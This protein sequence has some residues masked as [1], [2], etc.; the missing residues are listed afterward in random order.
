[1]ASYGRQLYI[2]VRASDQAS[3]PLRRIARDV[4]SMGNN[5][6]VVNQRVAQQRLVAQTAR[7]Q[8][9]TLA[10]EKERLTTGSRA[11]AQ[12]KAQLN[13]QQALKNNLIT[14]K[15]AE[16]ALANTANRRLATE[17]AIQDTTFRQNL[18]RERQR[19][20]LK[21]M[22][23]ARYTKALS[24]PVSR[25]ARYE[26]ELR[27]LAQRQEILAAQSKNL[28]AQQIR[29]GSV[30]TSLK[31][32]YRVLE[33]EYQRTVAAGEEMAVQ[34]AKVT[35]QMVRQAAA[36]ALAEA[37]LAEY[38]AAMAVQRWESMSRTAHDLS[39]SLAL[40]GAVGVAS[41]GIM[42]KHAADFN[43]Q[44]RLAATQSTVTG[45]QTVQ[46]VSKNAAFLQKGVTD[47]LASGKAV[48]SP[49]DLSNSLYQVFSSVTLPGDQQNQLRQGITLIKEFNDVAKANFGLVDL[50]EVTKAGIVIMNDFDVKVKDIPKALNTMQAAVRYG[51]MNMGEFVGTFNN[52]APAAKA[53]GYSFQSM[54][55]AI[56]F[57]S[58]KFPNVRVASAGYAR[59][60]EILARPKMVENLRAQGVEITN[61]RTKHMLPLEDIITKLVKAYPQLAKG[62]TILQNFFSEKSG[63]MG[64]IQARRAFTFLATG[65]AQY[66]FLASQI[67]GDRNELEKSVAAMADAPAVKWEEF[68]NQVRALTLVIGQEAI[69]ALISIGHPIAVAVHWFNSLDDGT[70]HLI[71][72][73]GVFGSVGLLASAG[74]LAV[75]GAFGRL[76]IMYKMLQSG[77]A[78]ERSLAMTGE[79]ASRTGLMFKSAANA[80]STLGTAVRAGGAEAGFA[81]VG[82]LKLFGTVGLL[83]TAFPLLYKAGMSV[84][85]M[86]YILS[87]ALTVLAAKSAIRWG[88]TF[89]A[90]ASAVRA[91]LLMLT[92][93]PWLITVTFLVVGELYLIRKINDLQRMV[94]QA[95]TRQ[96]SQK[97]KDIL[98]PDLGD[99]ITK[100]RA[101]GKTTQE[102]YVQLMRQLGAPMGS[103]KELDRI[104]YALDNVAIHGSKAYKQLQAQAAE[105]AKNIT[106]DSRHALQAADIVAEA[107]RKLHESQTRKMTNI[108]GGRLAQNREVAARNQRIVDFTGGRQTMMQQVPGFITQIN[109]LRRA[110]EQSPDVKHIL[111][112]QR[113][114][115]G[116]K[117]KLKNYPQLY[118]AITQAAE[119]AFN[120]SVPVPAALLSTVPRIVEQMNKL[121]RVSE[122]AP[123]VQ[124]VLAYNKFID[125]LQTRLTKFPGLYEAINTV[126]EKA[127]ST[128]GSITD[129]E[130]ITRRRALETMHRHL[131]KS[132]SRSYAAWKDY[133][134]QLQ[135]LNDAATNNQQQA[136]DE[137]F[138]KDEA[139]QKKRTDLAKRAARERASFEQQALQTLQTKYE[140]FY[141]ANKTAL[142]DLFSGPWIQGPRFQNMVQFGMHDMF[143][144]ATPRPQ[145]ALK[146]LRG[147]VNQFQ[148]FTGSL[149]GLVQRGL[150]QEMV[151]QLRAQGPEGQPN[152]DAV[153]RMTKKQLQEYARL[154]AQGQ[155]QVLAATKIDFAPEIRKWRI[156]GREIAKAIQQGIS[157]ENFAVFGLLRKQILSDLRGTKLPGGETPRLPVSTTLTPNTTHHI[158]NSTNLTVP[159]QVSGHFDMTTAMKHALFEMRNKK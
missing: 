32:R 115:D 113:Y 98:V 143:G 118:Q 82:F 33:V 3:R 17:R 130:Y 5:R 111:A 36:I 6:R 20:A 4:Q 74:I 9:V 109:R 110:S 30:V 146:D 13:A 147:Q 104:N 90:E 38:D 89:L 42:A 2:A 87:T 29:E 27:S 140:E 84:K 83:L 45:Q 158:D 148:R 55:E 73:I 157:D 153:S 52:A 68:I 54:A 92:A 8:M 125:D 66:H 24:V 97:V 64:T 44:L 138:R 46:Q 80:S 107:F 40:V 128:T 145:D 47:L 50:N 81:S 93:G 75:V 22:G 126:A 105:A 94:D 151:N 79:A 48:G 108:E 71:A 49:E 37:K 137:M 106:V 70:K 102:I 63:T 152:I 78:I 77:K 135:Q 41:F 28:T 99:R 132:H 65:A 149:N 136:G 67:R 112:Y 117:T 86:L 100:M 15:R 53:A 133:Y 7:G 88:A 103:T 91:A 142:G 131:V 56:A 116:L 58:R 62:G 127:F 11:L 144:R 114:L 19:R 129:R 85:D 34:A 95:E 119:A 155:K 141:N 59:L 26:N 18:F 124:N 60:T 139:N 122:S 159:T 21:A 76:F 120:K 16:E 72:T 150:P 14:Q 25:P 57:L 156:H 101:Q 154:W 61:L 12:Q 43:T 134:A 10:L 39:R 69:P 1:M 96:V 31:E 121:R 123:N 23:E 51:A 35:G